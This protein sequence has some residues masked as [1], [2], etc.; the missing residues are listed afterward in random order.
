MSTPHSTD[1]SHRTALDWWSVPEVLSEVLPA[2]RS[3]IEEH[4][5]GYWD[6]NMRPYPHEFLEAYLL[7]IL[8]AGPV[9][10]ET[11]FRAAVGLLEELLTHPDPDLVEATVR[12]VIE[13]LAS[14]QAAVE[15]VVQACTSQ[16]RHVVETCF[17]WFNTASPHSTL[18]SPTE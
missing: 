6:L 17:S 1:G 7:P 14:S 3:D 11:S 9:S 2:Q 13:R 15:A 8:E 12:S 4:L 18:G 5:L 10:A 16:R